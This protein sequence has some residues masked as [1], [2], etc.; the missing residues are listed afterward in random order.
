M[1]IFHE[2]GYI[3]SCEKHLIEENRKY[4]EAKT[5]ITEGSQWIY[6]FHSVG[7]E[8]ETCVREDIF[9]KGL[10]EQTKLPIV[11]VSCEN[12]M[13]ATDGLDRSFGI[14]HLFTIDATRF[15]NFF[16]RIKTWIWAKYFS[17]STYNKKEKL[18]QIKYRG[19]TCGDAIHDTILRS[20]PFN[21][22][23]SSNFNFDCFDIS[24]STY[25]WYIRY[26]LSMVDKAKELFKKRKPAYV[27]TAETIYTPG[28]LMEAASAEGAEVLQIPMDCPSIAGKIS[29]GNLNQEFKYA[30]FRFNLVEA[31]LR[32]TPIEKRDVQNIFVMETSKADKLNLLAALGI[33]NT[34]KNVFLMLHSL[35]D[36]PQKNCRHNFYKDYTEWFVDTLRIVREIKNVNWIVKDH[37]LAAFYGQDKYVKKVFAKYQNENLYWCDKNISGMNIKDIADCVVT[38]AGNV[39]IEFWSYGIPTITTSDTYYCPWNISYNMKSREEYEETLRHIDAVAKPS[40]ES[41][42]LAQKY[43]LAMKQMV[44]CGDDW[45]G[46]LFAE[47]FGQRLEC[48][49]DGNIGE[50]PLYRFCKAY[51]AALSEGRI[52]DSAIYQLKNVVDIA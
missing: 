31:Y 39:G 15:K 23:C 2:S 52:E 29:P 30:D 14:Q 18:F 40:E 8:L 27:V 11:A 41:A 33:Q 36:I 22:K 38:C 50:A 44:E 26:A 6:V 1:R 47:I 49:K 7:E 9:A 34:H 20:A 32:K 45:L 19:L 48:L 10:Q 12:K 4:W 35:T 43:L 51:R 3:R 46:G 5:N 17:I 37:P 25:C 24:R 28:L 21:P 16:S 42:Q 13:K